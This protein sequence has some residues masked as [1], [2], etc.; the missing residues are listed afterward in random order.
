MTPAEKKAWQ[1]FYG[2]SRYIG[3]YVKTYMHNQ[4]LA[5]EDQIMIAKN[6][7]LFR[8]LAKID[9]AWY[10]PKGLGEAIKEGTVLAY[11]EKMLKDERSPPNVWKRREEEMEKKTKYA[12]RAGVAEWI[13]DD[14]TGY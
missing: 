3:R 8:T 6:K 13:D 14:C 10:T 2:I 12:E 11:Y 5:I 1:K 9:W 4:G 7:Y